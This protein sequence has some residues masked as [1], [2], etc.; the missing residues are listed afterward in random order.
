[1]NIFN[2]T[3]GEIAD[4]RGILS[5]IYRADFATQPIDRVERSFFRIKAIELCMTSDANAVFILTMLRK[6][7]S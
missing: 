2:L 3:D 1:M 5:T 6:A 7:Q 4:V